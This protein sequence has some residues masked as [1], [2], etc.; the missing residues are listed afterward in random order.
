[1]APNQPTVEMMS[2]VMCTFNLGSVVTGQ[3]LFE[4]QQKGIFS[5]SIYPWQGNTGGGDMNKRTLQSIYECELISKTEC[6]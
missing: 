2:E 4:T 3:T 1:M 6:T 5:Y